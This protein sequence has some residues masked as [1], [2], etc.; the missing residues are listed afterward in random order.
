[1]CE[2]RCRHGHGAIWFA[3]LWVILMV[4]G[5]VGGDVD[6]LRA[7]VQALEARP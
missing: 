6:K 5:V 2:C 7:R 4:A 1:M 3:I